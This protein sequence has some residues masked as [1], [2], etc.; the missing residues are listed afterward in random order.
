MINLKIFKDQD[1]EKSKE[2]DI[3]LL[4]KINRYL[5]SV[6]DQIY[7]ETNKQKLEVLNK[8]YK[9]LTQQKIEILRRIETTKYIQSL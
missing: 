8:K 5:S 3:Q 7:S 1:L 2:L 9:I 4:E 6:L